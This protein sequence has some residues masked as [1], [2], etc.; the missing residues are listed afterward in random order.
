MHIEEFYKS[1]ITL[2]ILS[3]SNISKKNIIYNLTFKR[4]TNKNILVCEHLCP[5]NRNLSI[6][7]RPLNTR[8]LDTYYLFQLTQ[9]RKTLIISFFTSREVKEGNNIKVI[10]H[11]T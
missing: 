5:Q 6:N 2:L 1:N 8:L 4:K 10:L 7:S 9:I 3:K 11:I